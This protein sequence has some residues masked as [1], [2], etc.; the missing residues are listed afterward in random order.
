MDPRES[1]L[2]LPP[3]VHFPGGAGAPCPACGSVHSE[4]FYGVEGIPVHSCV[5]L[6]DAE[7]ARSFPK[8]DLSLAICTECGFVFNEHFDESRIDYSEDYEETQGYSGTFRAF[9]TATIEQLVSE[10]RLAG[11]TILEIGCGRGDFLEQLCARADA[12]GI[13]IDPSRTAGRVD[14][15]AGRGLRFLHAEYG[16][17]H[18]DLAVDGIACRH[19]LEHIGPVRAVADSVAQHLG[20][21]AQRWSFWEVP[22]T[23]RIL[24]AGAFWDVYYEHVSY[25]SPASLARLFDRAGFHLDR[26]ERVYGD[27]YLHLLARPRAQGTAPHPLPPVQPMLDKARAFAESCRAALSEWHRWLQASEPGSVALW[28]SGSKA[29]GF[30]TTLGSWDRIDCVVDINP[31]KQGR[32]CAGSGHAIVAPEDLVGRPIERVL[33]MNPIYLDEIQSQLASLGLHP[34]VRALG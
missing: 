23:E 10:L 2:E 1:A 34:E 32:F 3:G 19:T 9:L 6:A 13:G 16:S 12:H 15:A 7:G 4:R 26:L 21:D 31:D 11:T 29:T 18:H 5:L 8:G 27:Q 14:L 24:E 22:D 25:F 28:G 17:E 20:G 30:L 33:I